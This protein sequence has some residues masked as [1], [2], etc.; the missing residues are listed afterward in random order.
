MPWDEMLLAH[1]AAQ[2]VEAESGPAATMAATLAELI[3]AM[4]GD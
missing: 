4:M 3:A 2:A 1:A